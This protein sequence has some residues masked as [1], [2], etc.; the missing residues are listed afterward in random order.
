MGLKTFQPGEIGNTGCEPH[1]SLK[2]REAI[3]SQRLILSHNHDL[4]EKAIDGRD[5]RHEGCNEVVH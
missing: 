3:L 1:H 2:Q 5:N 4:L